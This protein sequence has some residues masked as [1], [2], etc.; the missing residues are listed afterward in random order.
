MK[1]IGEDTLLGRTVYSSWDDPLPS[2]AR[3][4]GKKHQ[5]SPRPQAV[6]P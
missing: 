2:T 4:S 5:P 3:S 1:P 6:K